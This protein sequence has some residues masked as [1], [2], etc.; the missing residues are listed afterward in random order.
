MSKYKIIYKKDGLL[1]HKH[2]EAKNIDDLAFRIR[3]Q[4][5][6]DALLAYVRKEKEKHDT[7]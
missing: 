2:I 4:Y 7:E 5:G 3:Y 6:E 1:F